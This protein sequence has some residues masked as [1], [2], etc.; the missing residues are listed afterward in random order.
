MWG[1]T[2]AADPARAPEFLDV[3]HA[4]ATGLT[5]TGSGT[6]SIVTASQ[7]SPGTRV[8]IAGAGSEPQI[9]RADPAGRLAFMIDLGRA[10]ALEQG[11]LAEVAAAAADAGYFVTRRIHFERMDD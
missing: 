1:W 10:H 11:T 2:F 7:F 6:E 9:V 8:R 3:R 4:S 5:V